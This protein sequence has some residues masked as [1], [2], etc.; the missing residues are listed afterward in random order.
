MEEVLHANIFFFITGIAVIVFTFVSTIA[1]YHLIKIL[2]SVR[3]IVDRVEM[4]AE[5]IVD[6]IEQLRTYVIEESFL[7][8]FFRAALARKDVREDESRSRRT[9]P[10]AEKQDRKPKTELKI[11]HED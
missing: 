1:L 10:K 9:H 6:D 3:R 7:S 4:G 8:R 5:T 2:K 11:K